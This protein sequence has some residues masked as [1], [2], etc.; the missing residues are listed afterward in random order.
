[1]IICLHVDELL[2]F[3]SKVYVINY[4]KSFFINNI[5]KKDPCEVEVILGFKITRLEKRTFGQI[6]QF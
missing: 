2:I 4:V 1:M 3:G 6:S 5:D